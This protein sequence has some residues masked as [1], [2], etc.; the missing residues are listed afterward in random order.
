MFGFVSRPGQSAGWDSVKVFLH[1]L[2]RQTG[3]VVDFSLLDFVKS[4]RIKD[5][6]GIQIKMTYGFSTC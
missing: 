6:R 4:L 2:P 3:V 1:P 5:P